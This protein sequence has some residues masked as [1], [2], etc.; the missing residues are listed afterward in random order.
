MPVFGTLRVRKLLK[1]F[2]D[3]LHA[4]VRLVNLMSP[5]QEWT[6]VLTSLPCNLQDCNR[7]LL[8]QCYKNTKMR[9]SWRSVKERG[10]GMRACTNGMCKFA[11]EIDHVARSSV[12]MFILGVCH[13]IDLTMGH[14]FFCEDWVL[15]DMF[16]AT[17]I[18]RSTRIAGEDELHY[19]LLNIWEGSVLA[20]HDDVKHLVAL[21]VTYLDQMRSNNKDSQKDCPPTSS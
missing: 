18:H 7:G 19:P 4:I 21:L 5:S 12:P 3:V 8:L 10:I 2:V 11:E 17:K 6:A 1:I 9:R 14:R 16:L 13:T 20:V 15:H